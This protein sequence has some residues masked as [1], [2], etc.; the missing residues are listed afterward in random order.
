MV[1]PQSAALLSKP[2]ILRLPHAKTQTQLTLSTSEIT[3]HL[4]IGAGI[5]LVF[6]QKLAHCTATVSQS[7][8]Q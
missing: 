4:T 3:R 8:A 5:F 2:I 7:Q 1:G 6:P